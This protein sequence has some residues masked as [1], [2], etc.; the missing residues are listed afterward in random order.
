MAVVERGERTQGG[1]CV[2]TKLGVLCLAAPHIPRRFSSKALT[3]L[4]L[5][6]GEGQG[7]N[8]SRNLVSSWGLLAFATSCLS[9]HPSPTPAAAATQAHPHHPL[10]ATAVATSHLTPAARNSTH[11]RTHA[12]PAGVI[13]R[14][15]THTPVTG[16]AGTRCQV[17]DHSKSAATHS[18]LVA[19]ICID[20]ICV[21]IL[22]W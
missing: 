11:D 7:R 18:L 4:G 2:W 15:C 12:A 19:A 1:R 20:A 14:W 9:H 17:L 22:L 16:P 8:R 10:T 6:A 3:Q 5:G 21:C 13:D